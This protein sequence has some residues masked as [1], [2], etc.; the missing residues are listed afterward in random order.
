MEED[1]C[2][3]WR[4]M[5]HIGHDDDDDDQNWLWLSAG[6]QWLDQPCCWARL[7]LLVRLVRG[8]RGWWIIGISWTV[9][10]LIITQSSSLRSSVT[11]SYSQWL[12]QEQDKY[13]EDI[14]IIRV[15]VDILYLSLHCYPVVWDLKIRIYVKTMK[16][17]HWTK[18]FFLQCF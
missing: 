14:I 5:L 13:T 10:S 16:S 18:T 3:R 7:L 1:D 17:R 11:A 8:W 12:Y 9:T 4:T 6:L 2:L 15:Q